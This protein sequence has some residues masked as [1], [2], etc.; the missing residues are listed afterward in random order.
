APATPTPASPAAWPEPASGSG[1]G[2]G[3]SWPSYDDLYGTGPA[4]TAATPEGQDRAGSRG[5]HH[6]AQ[7]P[8]YPDYYR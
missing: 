4:G 8:D 6:R 3:A 7:E 1:A 2:A 5:N